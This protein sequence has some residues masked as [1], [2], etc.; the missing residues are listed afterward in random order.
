MR[1]IFGV[2]TVLGVLTGLFF[3]AVGCGGGGG[4]E[5]GLADLPEPLGSVGG[6]VQ[7]GTLTVTALDRHS[8][9]G[10]IGASVYVAYGVSTAHLS[11]NCS[12]TAVFT[13]LTPGSVTVTII[14]LSYI[15]VT[16]L[17]IDAAAVTIPLDA[18][19]ISRA[20]RTFTLN[21]MISSFIGGW[22]FL[23]WSNRGGSYPFDVIDDGSGNPVT[24]PDPVVFDLEEDWP[25]AIAS[26]VFDPLE[27]LDNIQQAYIEYPSGPPSGSVTLDLSS[28]SMKQVSGTLTVPSSFDLMSTEVS[29]YVIASAHLKM[30]ESVGSAVIFS[31]A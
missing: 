26:F 20:N 3:L 14:S 29:V 4:G 16:I 27:D 7:G 23:S 31:P 5:D 10:V 15:P 13:G 19:S 17:D 6:G 9:S 11:T 8:G 24:D 22:G 30:S 18:A 2:L 12:G 25:V 21:G 28:A 1:R